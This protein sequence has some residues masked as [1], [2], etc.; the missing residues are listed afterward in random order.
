[1]IIV[2]NFFLFLYKII[3]LDNIKMLYYMAVIR[4]YFECDK[5]KKLYLE[6]KQKNEQLREFTEDLIYR[7]NP[8]ILKD[9]NKQLE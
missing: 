4:E 1:M 9:L 3:N 7:I 5:Y 2:I 8:D 6:E